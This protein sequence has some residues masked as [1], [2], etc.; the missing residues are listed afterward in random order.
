MCPESGHCPAVFC[1]NWD[2]GPYD[3]KGYT[4]MWESEV[5]RPKVG[6]STF[7]IKHLLPLDGG[8][9]RWG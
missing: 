1:E 2:S 7:S 9:L 3:D 4:T 8:G 5:P 6:A